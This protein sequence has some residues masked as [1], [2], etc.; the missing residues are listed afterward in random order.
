MPV[1][2]APAALAIL[3]TIAAGAGSST[4]VLA[5]DSSL[6]GMTNSYYVALDGKDVFSIRSGENTH[7]PIPLG[8]HTVTV[9]CF[10]GWSATWKEDGK[11]FVAEQNTAS[12]FSISPNLTCAKIAQV[13]EVDGKAL[14]AKTKFIDPTTA[15]NK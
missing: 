12:Y 3:P 2:R 15:S 8:Q 4:L 9:K 10:G 6:V 14:V 11:T 1:A 13:N 7:F 5:R